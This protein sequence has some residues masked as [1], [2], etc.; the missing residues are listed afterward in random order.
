MLNLLLLFAYLA[1]MVQALYE[2]VLVE[3]AYY[4][5]EPDN[6]DGIF[7][8]PDSSPDFLYLTHIAYPRLLM[9]GKGNGFNR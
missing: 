7:M 6:C 4:Q 5:Q 9:L 8:S 2:I 1:L 3:H